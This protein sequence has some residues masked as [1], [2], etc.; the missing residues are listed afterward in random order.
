MVYHRRTFLALA[1]SVAL[2]GSAFAAQHI[3]N[4]GMKLL[5]NRIGTDGRHEIHKVG[6]HTVSVR[7][8][9]KKIAGVTVTH[10]TKGEVPVK[11]YK[12]SKKMVQGDGYIHT[13]AETTDNLIQPTDFRVAQTIVSVGYSFIDPAT[14]NEIIYWYPAEMVIDPLTGAVDYIPLT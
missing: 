14:G 4:D 6:E 9:N 10:R 1:G 3:H 7:V 2:A 11:K 13:A 5:G 8:Q 12:T